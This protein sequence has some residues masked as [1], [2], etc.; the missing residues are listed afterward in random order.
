MRRCHPLRRAAALAL[1]CASAASAVNAQGYPP[2]QPASPR[3]QGAHNTVAPDT[4]APDTVPPART[5]ST[6]RLQGVTVTDTPRTTRAVDIPPAVV[7][8][9]IFDGKTAEIVHVDSS[10]SN[11]SRDVTRQILAR[12][13]GANVSEL[14]AGG[15]PANGIG[16]RGLNPTQSLE[17]NVR[18]NGVNISGDLYGYNEV[19]YSPPTEL[20]DDIQIV[21]GAS[22]LAYG[23]QFGGAVN[24]LLKHGTPNTAP[25]IEAHE[26]AGGFGLFDTF[27]SV[28]GGTGPLTYYAAVQHRGEQGERPNSDYNQTDAYGRADVQLSDATSVGLEYTRFRNQVH[29]PGGLTDQEFDAS[30]ESS[31]RSRNWLA[32]PWNILEGHLDSRLSDRVHLYGTS[33][34]LLGQRYLVWLSEAGGPQE[35]DSI[36]PA[37]NQYAPREVDREKFYNITNEGRLAISHD[38][39]ARANTLT[40]GAREFDGD[41]RRQ[42]GGE[43]S[44]GSDFD[45][46]LLAPYT[47]DLHFGTMNA[48]VFAENLL[49]I[50]DRWTVTPGVRAEWLRSTITG[51]DN[52]GTTNIPGQSKTREFALGGV[53]T[54]Y[55]FGAPATIYAN[56]TTAY[57]PITYDLLTPFGSAARISP[58][59]QDGRGWDLDI[60]WRGS[61]LRGLTASVTGYWLVYNNREGLFSGIDTTQGSTFTEEATIG[62]SVARGVETYVSL[63]PFAAFGMRGA[64]AGLSIFDAA[65]Y[66]DAHYTSGMFNGN[67]VELAPRWIHRAGLT[68]GYGPASTTLQVSTQTHAYTDANNTVLSPDDADV[69][70][71]PGYTVVD[72][73][74]EYVFARRFRASF[75]VNNIGNVHY[76]TERAVEY[77]GPGILPSL[78]RSLTLGITYLPR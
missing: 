31:E 24:Y 33:S 5:D 21:R 73:S 4:V 57:R 45:M 63:S 11:T 48:A 3:H 17:L 58:N 70:I 14:E 60:G 23:P 50:T 10:E 35:V 26:A 25:A 44:T 42:G 39:F 7:N 12:I 19:Y 46:S 36:N 72:W 15:F 28:S 34:L 20:I 64:W 41:M 27:G 18:Q 53:G 67:A 65:A 77:P 69:G 78:G 30:P 22:S 51:L 43:G 76:F 54:E 9:I 74:L 75:A 13:P 71:I 16:F 8:G 62:N 2:T 61:P 49:H 37:T 52:G 55:T 66:D 59:L 38:L 29:M 40:I 47:T 68:Y 32:T 56:W 6:H 1:L